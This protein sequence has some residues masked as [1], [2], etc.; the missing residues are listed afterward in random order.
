[1]THEHPLD[2]A[3]RLLEQLSSRLDRVLARHRFFK[4]REEFRH[5]NEDRA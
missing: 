3:L 1:M 4:R 2:R 5:N